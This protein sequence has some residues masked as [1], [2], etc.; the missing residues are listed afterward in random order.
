M[1]LFTAVDV[2]IFLV[3]G[4]LTPWTH[5]SDDHRFLLTSA[6]WEAF[7]VNSSTESLGEHYMER[8]T[9]GFAQHR[10]HIFWDC[11]DRPTHRSPLRCPRSGGAPWVPA[12]AAAVALGLTRGS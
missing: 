5:I 8:T 1:V 2:A 7:L 9:Q 4:R 3:L 11:P 10:P 6:G 12:T